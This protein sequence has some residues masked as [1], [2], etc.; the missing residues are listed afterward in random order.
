MGFP[1]PLPLQGDTD[2]RIS[3]CNK[4]VDERVEQHVTRRCEAYWV[5]GKEENKLLSASARCHTGARGSEV[6]WNKVRALEI[7]LN[8]WRRVTSKSVTQSR[9]LGCKK[10][11]CSIGDMR[12][13]T[14]DPGGRGV[15]QK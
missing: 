10:F 15:S 9:H 13:S 2:R 4:G 11:M 7:D 5:Q 14:E 6:G 8:L 12:T 1:V 3:E